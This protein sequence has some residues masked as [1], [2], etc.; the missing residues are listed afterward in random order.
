MPRRWSDERSILTGDIVSQILFQRKGITQMNYYQS[1][2]EDVL[3]EMKSS[4]E[5]LSQ[6]EA[7]LRLS[8][9]GPNKLAEKKK[10][11]LIVR[12]FKQ[13]ADPMI[14]VLIAAAVVS[15]VTAV[16]NGEGFADV[17][18][19]MTVV[20]INA[21]LGVYQENKAEKA[22]EALQEMSAAQSKVIRGG[23]MM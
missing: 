2:A 14:L 11:P 10:T 12:F 7:R 22:I 21:V 8:E 13:M 1:T 9:Y 4:P 23:V 18:I 15:L 19:I 17:I 5:G 16:I 20:V 3:G 6:E